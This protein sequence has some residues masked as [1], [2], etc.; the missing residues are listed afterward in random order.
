MPE[1]KTNTQGATTAGIRF[2][3]PKIETASFEERIAP[4]VGQFAQGAAQ[5]F[6]TGSAEA[7]VGADEEGVSATVSN[8]F[9]EFRTLEKD[10]TNN[11]PGEI[12]WVR[13]KAI[14]DTLNT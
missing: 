2:A 13:D 3:A 8:A 7:L 6:A 14:Q 9:A 1:F 4:M 5:G 11:D 12:A 10:V